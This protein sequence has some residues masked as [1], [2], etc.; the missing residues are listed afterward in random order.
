[1]RPTIDHEGRIWFGEMNRNY[2]AFFDPHTETFQQ[3]TPPHAAFGIMAVVV[4]P[5]DTIW[6]SEQYANYLGQY[7]PATHQ[8]HTYALPTLS[9]P[10]PTDSKQTLILPSAPNDITFDAHGNVWF[11]EINADAIGMLDSK[12]GQFTHYPLFSQKS[13]QTL[14]PYGIAID[15]QGQ[16]WFTEANTNHLGQL[17]PRTGAVHLY[18]LPGASNPLMEIVSD[19]HGILWAT[20]FDQEILVRFDPAR[21]A[22]TSYHAP[23]AGQGEG[24]NYGL[25][26]APD[27]NIWLA[28]TAE[29][30]IARFDVTTQHFT[31][32]QLPDAKT[33]PFG[34]AI[35]SN[36]TLWFT[37]SIGNKIGVLTPK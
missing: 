26:L 31:A 13:I 4:A 30:S 14:D 34:I 19:A 20:T 11:T 5:D 35:A 29:H 8:F 3:I 21:S 6:F 25:A 2:I 12:T 24:G 23:G 10:D 32:Y 27:G 36:H 16:V 7:L 9:K 33:A 15:P 22:F 18:T 37:D 28:V 1:M 17:D